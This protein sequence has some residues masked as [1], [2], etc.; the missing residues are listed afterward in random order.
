MS[1]YLLDTNA[2]SAIINDPWGKLATKAFLVGE[3]FLVTSVIVSCELFYGVER[4]SPALRARVANSLKRIAVLSLGD[5]VSEHYARVR[6]ALD[7][8]GRPIGGN[9]LLIAAH[10]L[11][12]NATLVTDNIREFARVPGLVVEDWLRD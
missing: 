2:L 1:L 12:I 3:E 7:V 4:G 5:D 6:A 9:D 10:A 8:E 11:A